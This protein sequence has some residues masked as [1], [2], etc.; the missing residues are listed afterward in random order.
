MRWAEKEPNKRNRPFFYWEGNGM[1]GGMLKKT[2][3][4]GK[5][6]KRQRRKT[7]SL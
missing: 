6:R 2:P 4:G 1:D 7:M 5:N 3:E